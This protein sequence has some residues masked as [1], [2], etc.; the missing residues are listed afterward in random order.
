MVRALRA[1]PAIIANANPGKI[2]KNLLI[3]CNFNDVSR[4]EFPTHSSTDHPR[5][6]KNSGPFIAYF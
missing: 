5:R 4:Y 3:K 1:K 2:I 6:P